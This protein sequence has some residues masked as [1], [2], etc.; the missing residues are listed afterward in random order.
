V[1]ASLTQYSEIE[2]VT[3][4]GG[5]PFAQ[6]APLAALGAMCR[7]IGLSVVTFSGY[8]YISLKSAN[9]SDWDALLRVTDLLLSGPFVQAKRDFS[10]PWVGSKNQEFIFIT[11]RYRDLEP[12]LRMI[13]NRIEMTA[14]ERGRIL[15][16]GMASPVE[17]AAM[18]AELASI[19]LQLN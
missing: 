18:S 7:D 2:G 5:E 8:E 3:F 10:R 13:P 1:F 15:I 6:A 17:L 12:I 4:T 9:R 19:G 14:D 16:N 11:D